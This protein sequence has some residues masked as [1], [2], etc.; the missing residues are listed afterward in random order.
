L[1]SPFTEE[2]PHANSPIQIKKLEEDVKAFL[3]AVIVA[4]GLGIAAYAVLEKS[5]VSADQKYSSGSTR[6]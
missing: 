3:S 6:L 1:K 4:L 2:R 5:Q